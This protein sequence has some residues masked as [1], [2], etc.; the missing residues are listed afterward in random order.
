VFNENP[1]PKSGANFEKP[2]KGTIGEAISDRLNEIIENIQV[3]ILTAELLKEEYVGEEDVRNN[4][5]DMISQIIL[6]A[7]QNTVLISEIKEWL[8]QLKE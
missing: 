2:R 5:L 3:I 7:D 1:S 6:R 8:R 4:A